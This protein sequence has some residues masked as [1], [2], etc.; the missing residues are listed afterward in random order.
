M[1]KKK[2]E[3]KKKIQYTYSKSW[4]NINLLPTFFLLVGL[5]FTVF[6]VSTKTYYD[7]RQ[8]AQTPDP[9]AVPLS[10]PTI[11]VPSPTLT[12]TPTPTEAEQ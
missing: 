10:I 6:L 8:R 9:T 2:T 12:L 1:K 7:F 11:E 3:Q 5:I 4:N